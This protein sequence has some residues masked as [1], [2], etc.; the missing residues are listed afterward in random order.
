ML[1]ALRHLAGRL[2]EAA[3]TR[4][5]VYSRL[6]IPIPNNLLDVL[7]CVAIAEGRQVRYL[8]GRQ[9]GGLPEGLCKRLI[10]SRLAEL[11]W[12]RRCFGWS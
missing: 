11:A 10:L 1:A 8:A 3:S 12:Q 5:D 2:P 9:F 7:A 6:V 4:D